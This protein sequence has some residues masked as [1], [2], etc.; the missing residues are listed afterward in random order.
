[1][2]RTQPSYHNKRNLFQRIDRLPTGPEW[3]C[4]TIVVEGD[5]TDEAGNIL[6]E[7]VEIWMRD[8]LDCVKELLGN[9]QLASYL[10]FEPQL[11]FEDAEG[12]QRRIDEMHTG[13]WWWETQVSRE[14]QCQA[15][16]CLL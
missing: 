10:H 11:V 7:E 1:M 5:E 2:N 4:E 13:D 15:D 14:Y 12:N 8:V 6:T 9:H 3:R 16:N